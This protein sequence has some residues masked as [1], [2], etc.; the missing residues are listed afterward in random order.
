MCK[1]YSKKKIKKVFYAFEDPDIRTFKKAKKFL[2][3]KGIQTKLIH[4]K[5]YS[6]FYESYFYNKKFSVPF[7]TGK[8]AISKDSFTIDKQNKW[9]TNKVSRKIAHLIRNKYD[10][11]IS[12]SKSINHD[13][14]LLNCRI[15]GL[16][17]NKPD[18][19]IIDLNLR[20]KKIIIK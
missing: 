13:N 3:S 2:N 7:I 16:Q 8:I 11:I 4:I 5:R 1:H 20:I 9:I 17:N 12:T 19:I 18:L 15:N 10:C 14:S 6:K